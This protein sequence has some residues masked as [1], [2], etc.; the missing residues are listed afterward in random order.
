M[1]HAWIVVLF[2]DIVTTWKRGR[3]AI[4]VRYQYNIGNVKSFLTEGMK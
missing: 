3:P 1:T 2:T 4:N